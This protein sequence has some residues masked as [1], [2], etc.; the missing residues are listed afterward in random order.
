MEV[1]EV[2]LVQDQEEKAN[3]DEKVDEED[4][5]F[6]GFVEEKANED[7][8]VN[9]EDVK[10]YDEDF[11]FNGFVEEKANEDEKVKKRTS[12]LTVLSKRRPTRMRR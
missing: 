8:K 6:N 11:N 5:T 7:E 3:E 9:D 10:V 2:P 4:F 12:I 1:P